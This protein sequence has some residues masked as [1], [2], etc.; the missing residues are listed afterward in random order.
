MLF[1]LSKRLKSGGDHL[2]G[3]AHKKLLSLLLSLHRGATIRLMLLARVSDADGKRQREVLLERSPR[4]DT[5]I[6]S[7]IVNETRKKA[8]LAT[9]DGN[10]IPAG[11]KGLKQC[12]RLVESRYP[13]SRKWTVEYGFHRLVRDRK[14]RSRLLSMVGG[15]RA[16]ERMGAEERRRRAM[17]AANARYQEFVDLVM[18]VRPGK[19]LRI[20]ADHTAPRTW[21]VTVSSAGEVLSRRECSRRRDVEIAFNEFPGLVQLLRSFEENPDVQ[22]QSEP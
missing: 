1:F 16:A 10:P 18:E 17:K 8:P 2:A 6:L 4:G 14:K 11:Y 22:K 21:V 7:E 9:P 20:S 12:I 5:L 15:L 19:E 13:S 3:R